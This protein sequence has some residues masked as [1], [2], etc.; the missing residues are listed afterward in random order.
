MDILRY[1]V[2]SVEKQ[3]KDIRIIR[4]EAE[5]EP[6]EYLPGHFVMLHALDKDGNEMVKR[7]YSLASSPTQPYLEFCIK[8][9]DGQMTSIM[10]KAKEGDVYGVSGPMGHFIYEKQEKC[11][12][13]AGGTGI[14]P[15]MSM[16]RYI[17]DEKIKGQF[18]LFFSARKRS[19][20]LY[21]RELEEL[22]RSKSVDV[23]I[24]LTREEPK[25]WEGECGR[26]N[27]A[28]LLKYAGP[29]DERQWFLCGPLKMTMTMRDLLIKEGV[30]QSAVKFEGWG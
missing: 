2:T 25:S 10:K 5:G 18:T 23:V 8:M 12:F 19:L 29:L 27:E 14:A 4:M 9:I 17:R 22:A 16:L 11:A 26:I 6:L 20:I 7:P 13:I 15:F 24:T 28:M 3:A 21:A 30:D 1:R